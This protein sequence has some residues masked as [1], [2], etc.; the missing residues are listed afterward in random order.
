MKTKT[1]FRKAA[2]IILS[3][4]LFTACS[5]TGP[6]GPAGPK[7]EQGEKGDKGDKGTQ[8]NA[9]VKV[10]TKVISGAKWPTVGISSNGY[11]ELKCNAPNVLT[12]DVINNWTTL[13]YVNTSDFNQSGLA[14]LPYYSNRDIRVTAD[15]YRILFTRSRPGWR[16]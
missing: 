4:M 1:I 3:V 9:N 13:V 2:V 14:L 5:K 12:S 10:Y 16:T 6:Q 7:G 11:S 15:I 8:G